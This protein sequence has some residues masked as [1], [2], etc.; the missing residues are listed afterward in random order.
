MTIIY[1]N[2]N[3]GDHVH[4]NNCEKTMLVPCGTDICPECLA[5]GCLSWVD[6]NE[7]EK[8]AADIESAGLS[9]HQSMKTTEK[10]MRTRLTN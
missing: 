1:K 6:E 5:D 4:C 10:K 8:S 7:P 9:N 2:I 3:F